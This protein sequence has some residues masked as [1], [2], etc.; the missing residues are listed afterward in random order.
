MSLTLSLTFL[1]SLLDC[2]APGSTLLILST[3]VSQAASPALPLLLSFFHPLLQPQ[4]SSGLLQIRM[5]IIT[6]VSGDS[7]PSG[8]HSLSSIFTRKAPQSQLPWGTSVSSREKQGLSLVCSQ[9]TE[10]LF[11]S[12]STNIC[13]GPCLKSALCSHNP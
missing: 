1:L 6:P 5:C 10:S 4:Q 13:Q 8:L 9:G 12:Q 11:N 3:E 2:F 7:T